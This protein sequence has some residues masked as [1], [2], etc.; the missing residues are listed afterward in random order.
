MAG[1][2]KS[3]IARTVAQTFSN[4]GQLGASFFFRKGEGECG[5][6]SRFFTT[7]AM[8]L[9][10]HEPGM[11][12]GIRKAL[13]EDSAISQRVLKDQFEKLILQPLL[14]MQQ[15]CSQASARIVVIDALDECEQEQHIRTI[16]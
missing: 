10:A 6:A 2:G 11:L 13:N 15:A 8:D 5:N 3:T 16:L 4:R 14:E 7:M 9:V 1:T 12:P